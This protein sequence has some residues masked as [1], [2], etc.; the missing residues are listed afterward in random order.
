MSDPTPSSPR[1][2]QDS[3]YKKR[4]SDASEPKN[5]RRR[6]GPP[7][8]LIFG[9]LALLIAIILFLGFN[10]KPKQASPEE[11]Q[12][13]PQV[14]TQIPMEKPASAEPAKS[15]RVV[16]RTLPPLPPRTQV[17]LPNIASF[18]LPIH[19]DN[20]SLDRITKSLE[21]HHKLPDPSHVRTED[22]L[23]CFN[24]QPSGTTGISRGVT[25]STESIASPWKPSS[26]LFIITIRGA[27]EEN[28]QVNITFKPAMANVAR[29]RL[30]GFETST[31]PGF[32]APASTIL[33]AQSTA[34]L[35]LEIDPSISASELGSLQW[36][37]DDQPVAPVALSHRSSADPS[38]DAE[39]AALICAFGQW[40]D[41][42]R[43][44][45][46]DEQVVAA[47]ARE[48]AAKNPPQDRADF[49]TLIDRA[50]HQH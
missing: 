38:A 3:F 13:P 18:S 5:V 17:G 32:K 31:D 24:L 34:T 28:H 48:I 47:L 23:N 50:L 40:L 36:S 46:V 19:T 1:P 2:T 4:P 41:R 26:V 11:T 44:D 42:G 6:T 43:P 27:S 33:P 25:L 30:I 9:S 45:L 14:Q 7:I 15:I 12:T 22:L 10:K 8:K 21:L 49:L 35:V 20:G 16:P 37:I 39:F 29:Y